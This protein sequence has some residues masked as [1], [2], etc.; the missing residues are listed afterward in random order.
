MAGAAIYLHADRNGSRHPTL[1]AISAFFFLAI[2]LPVYVWHV[3]RLRH[4]R[5]L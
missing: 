4:A 1:W 5:R 2:T 3:Y